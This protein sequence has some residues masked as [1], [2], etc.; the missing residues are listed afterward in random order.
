MSVP[1]EDGYPVTNA[2]SGKKEV[3]L[4][5]MIVAQF[6]SIQNERILPRQLK[7]VLR[8]LEDYLSSCKGEWFSMYLAVFMF[9]HEISVASRDR[10]R[11][12]H[13]HRQKVVG[14]HNPRFRTKLPN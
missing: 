12:A 6:D 3:P 9:L 8:G 4:P 14:I 7:K 5:R 10:H 1:D 2:W 11:W 13:E